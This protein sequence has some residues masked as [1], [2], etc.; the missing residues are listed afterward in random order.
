M[1]RDDDRRGVRCQST[2]LTAGQKIAFWPFFGSRKALKLSATA[3]AL[4]TAPLWNL[5]PGW[6]VNVH[7]NRSDEISHDW[8]KDALY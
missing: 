3:S 7:V 6:S 1:H 2:F 8:N 5:R 4:A